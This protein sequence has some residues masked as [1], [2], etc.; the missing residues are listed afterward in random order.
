MPLSLIRQLGLLALQLALGPGDRH[1]FAGAHADQVAFEFGKG[2]ED[3]E[4]HLTHG[5]ER[6]VNRYANLQLNPPALQLIGDCPCIRN[7][8]RQAIE[9]GH[10]KRVALAGRSQRLNRKDRPW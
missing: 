7:R 8:P 5:V 4:E 9:L 10:D 1:P 2:R 6:I 3:V